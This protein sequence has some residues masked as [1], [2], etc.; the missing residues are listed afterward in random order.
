MQQPFLR[1]ISVAFSSR[2][3]TVS[4]P[5]ITM[6]GDGELLSWFDVTGI[7]SASIG[8]AGELLARWV[9]PVSP[10]E[11][12]VDRRLASL[13]FGMTLRP[14]GWQV[15]SPWDT[16]AGD[17]RAQDGWIRLH[18]N[19]PHHRVAALSVLGKSTDRAAL[20]PLVE[21]WEADALETA[22]VEAGGCAATMRS[23]EA[24]A[25]HPQGMAVQ[26]E[27][28]IHWHDHEPVEPRSGDRDPRRPLK[29]V[30]VLD[31]TRV[32]AGPVAGRFL[33]AYGADVLRIDPPNWDE[34]GVVPEVTLGKRCA[35]LDLKSDDDRTA[36]ETL[37]SEADILLHGYRADALAGLG[38]DPG[39][40]R[41]I[42][43]GLIDVSLNAYG[44]S[45]PWVNRRGF[46]SL[47]QMSSG[48][49]EYGRRMAGTD[50]PLPLPV[51][52]LDQ[53]TGY[54]MAAAVLHALNERAQTGRILS[55]RLSLA[56]V[57]HL[58][59]GSNRSAIT[60]GLTA[61][62]AFD[63]DPHVEQTHWG[64]A[65][66]VRFP[67]QI[68]GVDHFWDYPAGNLCTSPAEWDS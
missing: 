42:N 13:W 17:Y 46:D 66:R 33:A 20:A 29:G 3:Q 1:E 61:E 64:P 8:A 9:D 31:L 36:F 39:R 59:F 11:V 48:I 28:L 19:A 55:G 14:A 18:T 25:V 37:L 34:P 30:R 23:P 38:Y 16:I 4:L 27:P 40:L 35:A 47:L 53:A 52:A 12:K 44:W 7:A 41:A 49:A 50:K 22:I 58:L 32:L 57:A 10:C 63:L 24:W 15:P 21:K 60:G 2:G 51:Q 68:S 43:A 45:G 62:T 5:E 26:S 56:R 65:H 54:L 6:I 67:L